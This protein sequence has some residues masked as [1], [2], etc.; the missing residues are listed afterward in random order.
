M[1]IISTYFLLLFEA[2]VVQIELDSKK[3][4]EMQLISQI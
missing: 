3:M 2:L 4:L 1:N